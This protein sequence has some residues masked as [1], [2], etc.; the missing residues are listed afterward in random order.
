MTPSFLPPLLQP[1]H[2]PTW[3]ALDAQQGWRAATLDTAELSPGAGAL[4]LAVAAGD[5]SMVEESG[6]LGGLVPPRNVAV[7]GD[8]GVMLLDL[9]DCVLKRYDPCSCT[10]LRIPGVGGKGAG[11]RQFADPHAI[12]IAGGNLFVADTG[13]RRVSVFTLNGYQL[14]STLKPPAAAGLAQ[15]WTPYALAT[16]AEGR[17]YV[18]DPANGCVHRFSRARRWEMSISGLGTVHQL[19]V[20]CVGQLYV[21][22]AGEEP[23]VRLYDAH[24]RQV[25]NATRAG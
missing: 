4:T 18:S 22:V 1:P 13:N 7:D 10:F 21:G 12:A 24:G 8:G 6:S 17:L 15:P 19:A 11:P 5:R 14:R 23:V 25:G 20:D 9:L 2:D 16:D 3:L